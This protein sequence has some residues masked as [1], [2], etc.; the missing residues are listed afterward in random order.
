MKEISSV[1]KKVR[2]VSYLYNSV[3]EKEKHIN[4]MESNEYECLDRFEDNVQATFRKFF[5]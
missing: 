3:E 2:Y 5:D 4:E 1:I